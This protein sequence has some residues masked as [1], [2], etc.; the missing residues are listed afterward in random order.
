MEV[1]KKRESARKLEG[2]AKDLYKLK[3]DFREI[4]V[5]GLPIRDEG[6]GSE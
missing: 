3:R 2:M 5:N 4:W 6:L 1:G